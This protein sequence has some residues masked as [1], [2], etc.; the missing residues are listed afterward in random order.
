VPNKPLIICGVVL[1]R[2]KKEKLDFNCAFFL[3]KIA[4]SAVTDGTKLSRGHTARSA[5]LPSVRDHSPQRGEMSIDPLPPPPLGLAV[6]LQ[7]LLRL[8]RADLPRRRRRHLSGR[9]TVH[10]EGRLARQIGKW[11]WNG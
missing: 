8:R 4:C 7:G 1:I 3:K 11:N 9:A 10:T 2:L 5:D 6:D